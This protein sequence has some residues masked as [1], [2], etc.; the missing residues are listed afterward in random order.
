[1]EQ[2]L[3]FLIENGYL[4]LFGIVLIQ[5]IG[6]PISAV[7]VFLGVGALAATGQLSITTAVGITLLASLPLDSLWFQLGRRR[8]HAIINKLCR[9]SLEP[10]SCVR[11]TGG[12]YQRFGNGT[13]IV[14]KFVPGLSIIALPLAGSTRMSWRTFLL[15]DS[16]GTAVWALVNLGIGYLFA[17]QIEVLADWAM[18][19][20]NYVLILLVAPLAAWILWKFYRRHRFLQQIR[21]DR[22]TPEEL[23][24]KLESGESPMMV[25]LRHPE[26][27]H[28]DGLTIPGAQILS[29]AELEAGTTTFPDDRE[30]ILFC[31]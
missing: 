7:P 5:Q 9:V 10:D 11:R 20:G 14:A 1:M 15:W 19:L 21:M 23:W 16:L 28:L 8:G 12:I 4:F 3:H 24:H 25:D 26:E 13:L 31:T 30:I 29:S 18:T 27:I 17:A 22:I 6:L 2:I